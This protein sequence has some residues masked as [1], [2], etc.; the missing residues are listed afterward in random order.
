MVPYRGTLTIPKVE[1]ELY[2]G[3]GACESICP[4]SPHR[5]IQVF[6]NPI[7][8]TAELPPEEE[9]QKKSDRFWIFKKNKY[10]CNVLLTNEC[11]MMSEI[12]Y[13]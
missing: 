9:I 13:K 7:H 2:I 5:A 4:V 1:P 11:F 6:A 12:N 10:F 3:C 8:K